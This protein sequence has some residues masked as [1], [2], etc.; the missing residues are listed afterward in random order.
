M[1]KILILLFILNN[2]CFASA[3]KYY[4]EATLESCVNKLNELSKTYKIKSYKIVPPQT[5]GRD[6]KEIYYY[7]MIIEIEN[8]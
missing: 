2:M 5:G 6:I 1:K 4:K 7:N 3:F 8:K